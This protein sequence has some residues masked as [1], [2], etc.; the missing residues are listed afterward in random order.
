MCAIGHF[1]ETEG[2]A[3]TAISLVRENVETMRPPRSL[4]VPFPLGRPLGAPGNAAFQHRVVA[5]ALALLERPG[6]PVLED[7]PED[8]P[9]TL[10][11]ETAA[12]PVSFA[13]ERVA[14]DWRGRLEREV[15]E[16]APWHELGRQRRGRS[17]VGVSGEGVAEACTAIARLLD[18][19]AAL[20]ATPTEVKALCLLLEDAKAFYTEALTATPG[21]RDAGVVF[22]ELWHQSALGE[23]IRTLRA[24]YEANPRLRP[25][26]RA[27]APRQA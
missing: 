17:T 6:G 20:P 15:A 25:I 9:D 8:A 23:A 21:A 4:W 10:P 5:A 2:L 18:E 24:R 19:P 13:T 11:V 7:F 16:L 12:C 27:I 22:D 3:T 1:L 26:A 14:E